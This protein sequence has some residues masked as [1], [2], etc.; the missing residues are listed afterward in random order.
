MNTH[1]ITSLQHLQGTHAFDLLTTSW[2]ALAQR[3]MT[4]TPFQSVAYQ[5]A[6]WE[7]LGEGALH[8][9]VV[10]S[11][12]QPEGIICLN[13]R[14]GVVLFNASK[15]E[16]D[17]LD[18]LCSADDAPRIWRALFAFLHSDRAPAWHT[19][20]FWNLPAHSPSRALVAQ[21]S[22]EYQLTCQ[23]S[24]AEVCPIISLPSSFE[25]YLEGLENKQRHELRRKLRRV[26]H[27]EE[28]VR[29]QVV[30]ESAELTPAIH[31]FLQLLQQST[32]EKRAW[33]TPARAELFHRVAQAALTNNTLE[34][35]LVFVENQ[36][37]AAKFAF[38]YRG[39]L[40]LY[41]SGIDPNAFGYLSIGLLLNVWSIRRAIEQQL[42][43]YDFLR[44]NEPY[45][46][47][48]GAHDT[49]LYRLTVTR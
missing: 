32:P 10:G 16:S 44:G 17:Y 6:W 27:G 11:L 33:L 42:T 31:T 22:A 43:D 1:T 5:R 9:L 20:D 28:V 7:L 41:N 29:L 36:P 21:L 19:L 4:D 46:Y 24:V 37:A 40:W 18:I 45:K 48:L 2:D 26:E 35:L 39:K 47:R 13:W 14:D 23:E 8:T 12:E 15:E 25:A 34:L 30:Q 38:N 3:S 49:Q